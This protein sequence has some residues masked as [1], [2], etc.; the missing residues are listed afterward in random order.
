MQTDDYTEKNRAAW[1]QAAPVH[2]QQRKGN[3]FE[4]VQH[5][6]FN[7]LGAVEQRVLAEIGI[8]GKK[9]AQFCCNNGRELISMLKMGAAYGMGFDISDAF[10]DEARQ[11]TDLAGVR[12]DFLRT[13]V[14]QIA[15]EY[16]ASFDLVFI[17]IGALTWLADLEKLFEVCRRL[18]QPGG[19]LFIYEMHPFLDMMATT[20][21][22]E[23]DPQDEL[24]IAF[25]YFNTEPW[26][27]TDGLDYYGGTTYDS[28]ESIGF[29]HTLSEILTAILG[30]GLILTEYREYPHDISEV[31][32]YLEKYQKIPMC[33]SLV[34]R[35]GGSGN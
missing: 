5:P 32:K 8:L 33:Y 3:L 34:A 2:R 9:V 12:C 11:L 27:S 4:E 21:D 31:F 30:S 26:V 28:V 6:S 18:L 19:Y 1:N 17:S 24:K 29:P 14:L 15:A 16:D 35:R 7:T 10:I 22:P 25:P 13:D 23:Y 20:D